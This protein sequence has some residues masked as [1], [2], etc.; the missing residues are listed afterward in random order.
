VETKEEKKA[1]GSRRQLRAPSRAESPRTQATQLPSPSTQIVPSTQTVSLPEVGDWGYEINQLLP[2][3]RGSWVITKTDLAGTSNTGQASGFLPEFLNELYKDHTPIPDLPVPTQDT[4]PKIAEQAAWNLYLAKEV[5]KIKAE[6]LQRIFHQENIRADNLAKEK[7]TALLEIS[8]L[9]KENKSLIQQGNTQTTKIKKRE[10]SEEMAIDKYTS[11]GAPS[12]EKFLANIQM[13]FIIDDDLYNTD[14]KKIAYALKNL[15]GKADEWGRKNSTQLLTKTYDEFL[16]EFRKRFRDPTKISRAVHKLDNL[17]QGQAGVLMYNESWNDLISKADLSNESDQVITKLKYMQGLNPHVHQK[18]LEQGYSAKDK[19]LQELQ[20][21]AANIEET[22]EISRSAKDSQH[23]ASSSKPATKKWQKQD[24]KP[25]TNYW[26]SNDNNSHYKGKGKGSY[27]IPQKRDNP[28]FQ[29]KSNYNSGFKKKLTCYSCGKIG[30]ISPKCRSS[31]EVKKK[32]RESKGKFVK[33]ETNNVE[34]NEEESENPDEPPQAPFDIKEIM[35]INKESIRRKPHEELC[36]INKQNATFKRGLALLDSGSDVNLISIKMVRRLKLKVNKLDTKVTL[37]N[38][39]GEPIETKVKYNTEIPWFNKEK[40]IEGKDIFVVE[41]LA[42]WDAILGTP[43]LQKYQPNIN[44]N[45]MNIEWQQKDKQT[46]PTETSNQREPEIATIEE[47]KREEEEVSIKLPECIKDFVDVFTSPPPGQLPPFRQGFDCIIKPKEPNSKVFI[48]PYKTDLEKSQWIEKEI[49]KLLAKGFISPAPAEAWVSPAFLVPKKGPKQYRMVYDYRKLND[50]TE[51]I[52]ANMHR[53]DYIANLTEGSNYYVVVDLDNAFNTTIRMDPESRKYTGFSVQGSPAKGNNSRTWLGGKWIW[54]VMP[55]GLKTAPMYMQRLMD[56][57]LKDLSNNVICYM[58]DVLIH[59]KTKE[60]LIKILR[61]VLTIFRKEKIHISIDKCQFLKE[62]VQFLGFTL[63]ASGISTSYDKIEAI[64][65]WEPP[66]NIKELQ[67]FIGFVTF[68]RTFIPNFSRYTQTLTSLLK[69]GT[70]WTW[71]TREQDAFD[72]IKL[73]ISQ[74]IKLIKP[75]IDEQFYLRTDASK[76]AMGAVL[77]QQT[78]KENEKKILQPIAFMS[79]TFNAAQQNY[80]THDKEWLAII[81]AFKNWIHLL[82]GSPWPIIIQTDHANLENSIK[83]KEPMTERHARWIR[84]L[85]D[86][87]ISPVYIKGNTNID[88]DALSRSQKGEKRDGPRDKLLELFV[89]TLTTLATPASQIEQEIFLAQQ[90]HIKWIQTL[91]NHK[92][93]DPEIKGQPRT[94]ESK[95][96][97]PPEQK[98][99]NKI[100]ILY[101]D[102]QAAGHRGRDTTLRLIVPK[103]WWPQMYKDIKEYVASCDVCQK[104]KRQAGKITGLMQIMDPPE[105]PW[106]RIGYDLITGLPKSKDHLGIEYDA[107]LVVVDHFTKYAHFIRTKTTVTSKEIEELMFENVFKYH[108]LPQTIISDRGVQFNT[109]FL[110]DT[111]KKLGIQPNFTTAYHPQSNGQVER[112]NQILENYLRAVTNYYHDDWATTLTIAEMSYNATPKESTGYSP[113]YLNNAYEPNIF[114]M[115][116]SQFSSRVPQAD[117][118]WKKVKE[119]REQTK[120]QL[121]KTYLKY[122]QN[123]DQHRQ[124][125]PLYQ[126]NQKVLLNAKNIKQR[127]GQGQQGSKLNEPW[128]G[129]F[130]IKSKKGP[131]V[132]ELDLP[133]KMKIHN[134]FNETLLRPYIE[135]NNFDRDRKPL[136][137]PNIEIPEE[138][139]EIEKILDARKYHNR[140]ELLIRWKDF[141]PQ[142]DSWEPLNSVKATA[143]ESVE[144]YYQHNP[145]HPG[146]PQWTPK[147]RDGVTGQPLTTTNNRQPKSTIPN[148]KQSAGSNQPLRRSTRSNKGKR[149]TRR[150]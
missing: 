91:D 141:G 106:I 79:K 140:F 32:Y 98:L 40:G 130:K 107:I 27:Q 114:G 95:L 42:N 125:A 2:K 147:R 16:D 78:G 12:Q 11:D 47:R 101:H 142:E 148:L 116:T 63:D 10:D 102:T 28:P 6:A 82:K 108:G 53:T 22:Y 37:S 73:G 72:K 77:L 94:K 66:K 34:I 126:P 117:E 64:Q 124:E 99:K 44:W 80:D 26:N 136:L 103:Y 65:N 135:H 14:K 62:S 113:F 36:F 7:L 71:T 43:F 30:H 112:I 49:K 143:R 93:L 1:S 58:D 137:R 39:R 61:Q 59:A 121:R 21:K 5:Y 85:Q 146:G 19:S 83:K 15:D 67:R 96:L 138:Q 97:V 74:E 81:L 150:F 57:L 89:N 29:K 115:T 128:I 149:T 139:W 38:F 90:K 17:K 23:K 75:N 120:E 119:I 123:Y 100:M 87:K 51:D 127:R 118:R 88:A 13:V 104:S 46:K 129:P 52:W 70:P 3:E 122:K 9:E 55:F 20:D 48:K 105:G 86:F 24:D 31:E 56:H 54:N 111:Y 145:T 60:E 134:V 133:D 131:G 8:R 109:P 110:A 35:N 45:N 68:N 41:E 4:E 25:K 132:Y 144:E 84:F 76:Y 69:K 18:L 50:E 33:K 92:A